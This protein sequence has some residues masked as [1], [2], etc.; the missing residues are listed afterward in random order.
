MDISQLLTFAV[1]NK[2]SDLHLSTGLPP[3]LRV[4]GDV[5]R[6]NLPALEESDTYA[7]ITD[8]MSDR[9]KKDLEEFWECDF[10]FEIPGLSR[11]R[12]NAFRQN[13][14]TGA[15][16]RMI[17]SEILTLEKLGAPAI[18]KELAQQPQ[19][20]VLVTGPTGSGKSTTLAA[21]ID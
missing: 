12:V 2:A 4:D 10:S 6:I 3:M 5:R 8:I 17:P 7:M 19:G 15:V 18:F 1:R 9:Q 13:R 20:L 16:F 14:G 21:M 11:F